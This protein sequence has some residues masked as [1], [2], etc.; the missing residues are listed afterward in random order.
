MTHVQ[1]RRRAPPAD[2]QRRVVARLSP[3]LYARLY[4]I[5]MRTRRTL[6]DLMREAVEILVAKNAIERQRA[7]DEAAEGRKP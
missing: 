5:K 1:T 4:T 7:D 6:E 3:A 2:G